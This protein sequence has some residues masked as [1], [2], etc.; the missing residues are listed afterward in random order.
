MG[1]YTLVM[2]V[3]THEL[4]IVE[5]D[6][7]AT[8][9][10]ILNRAHLHFYKEPPPEDPLYD[11]DGMVRIVNAPVFGCNGVVLTRLQAA[12]RSEENTRLLTVRVRTCGQPQH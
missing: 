8:E 11:L 12:A 7:G 5:H 2:D 10:H 4:A 9:K 6:K 3:D 1:E